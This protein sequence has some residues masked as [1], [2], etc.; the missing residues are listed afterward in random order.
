MR[1]TSN[2]PPTSLPSPRSHHAGWRGGGGGGRPSGLLHEQ[3]R[4]RLGYLLFWNLFCFLFLSLMP[5]T[6]LVQ[7]APL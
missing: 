1:I 3:K 4:T 6:H 7:R 5:G 2:P